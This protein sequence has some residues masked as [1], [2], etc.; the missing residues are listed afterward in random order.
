MLYVML[1]KAAK[2]ALKDHL[3]PKGKRDKNDRGCLE[4]NMSAGGAQTAVEMLR[5][6]TQVGT[7]FVLLNEFLTFV[8]EMRNAG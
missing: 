6:C 7:H 5:L 8:T 1:V 2:R 4:W 3:D